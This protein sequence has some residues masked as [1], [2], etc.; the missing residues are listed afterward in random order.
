MRTEVTP[1]TATA[2]DTEAMKERAKHG[3]GAHELRVGY[4]IKKLKA[5]QAEFTDL[6]AELAPVWAAIDAL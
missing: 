4:A 1:P 3:A 6:E 5:V 2:A